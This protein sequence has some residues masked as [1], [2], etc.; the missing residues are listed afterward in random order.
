MGCDEPD[1]AREGERAGEI[2]V[3][4][5]AEDVVG[6]VDAQGLL[7]DPKEG[8]AGH[9]ERKEPGWPDAAVVS[10]PQGTRRGQG[11]R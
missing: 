6:R 11:S 9:V 3:Q 5:Q 7:E 1:G 10:E 4:A 2:E 8:V